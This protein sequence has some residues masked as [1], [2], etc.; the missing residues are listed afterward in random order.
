M[1]VYDPIP[2]ERYQFVQPIPPDDWESIRLRF[3][4]HAAGAE[5][6]P[7]PLKLIR[8]DE[9][10]K[11]ERGDWLYLDS[12][13]PVLRATAALAIKHIL[14][15]GD[16]LL[17]MTCGKEQIYLLRPRWT[18]DALDEAASDI[19]RFDNGRIG[20]IRKHVFKEEAFDGQAIFYIP[21]IKVST[22]YVTDRFVDAW[23]KAGLTGLA[24]KLLWESPS[25]VR[26]R[27]T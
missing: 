17:P 18:I 3:D 25:Q 2:A 11:Q 1:K 5:W 6:I 22:C 15:P 21:R 10:K 27:H 19:W 14:D 24:P 23:N 9:G 26:R 12:H 4:A 7:R 13:I 8:E 16:Q 20:A